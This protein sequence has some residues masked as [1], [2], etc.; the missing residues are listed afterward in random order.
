MAV[1]GGRWLLMGA[2][3]AFGVGTGAA[4]SALDAAVQGSVS[5]SL[6]GAATAI[7]YTAFDTLV[8]FGG[9]GLGWLAGMTDY[10]VMFA[11][12]GGIVLVGL[13]AGL[14]IRVGRQASVPQS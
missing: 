10:G 13:L 3:M 4:S 12:A 7:Q 8:G 5:P 9:L 1:A 11:A 14:F 6:R 2:A